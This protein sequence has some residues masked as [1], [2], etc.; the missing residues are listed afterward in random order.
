MSKGEKFLSY[1]DRWEFCWFFESGPAAMSGERAVPLRRIE[2]AGDRNEASRDPDGQAVDR[3]ELSA[4]YR[5]VESTIQRML[6]DNP[7]RGETFLRDLHELYVQ[8][9]VLAGEWE[10]LPD[11][12]RRVHEAEDGSRV[13]VGNL[14]PVNAAPDA[15]PGLVCLGELAEH[16]GLR[17]E[18]LEA[19]RAYERARHACGFAERGHERLELLSSHAAEFAGVDRST[20]GRVET[21]PKASRAAKTGDKEYTTIAVSSDDA[22]DAEKKE[23]LERILQK[24]REMQ[25]TSAARIARF[26]RPDPRK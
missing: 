14:R 16:P 23:T 13:Q 2:A 20:M 7:E 22:A 3:L 1:G 19:C 24:I 9:Q 21:L 4:L 18:F 11:G 25:G 17:A 6:A 8:P 12:E 15:I 5:K 10:E 26:A